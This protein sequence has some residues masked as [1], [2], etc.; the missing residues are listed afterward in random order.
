MQNF[1]SI[2]YYKIV[3]EILQ[4][5][6]LSLHTIVDFYTQRMS[7]ELTTFQVLTDHMESVAMVLTRANLFYDKELG[8]TDI[9]N[10][11]KHF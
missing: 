6:I 1:N 5:F 3:N 9:F 4:L 7:V 2:E 11:E 10:F 8:N